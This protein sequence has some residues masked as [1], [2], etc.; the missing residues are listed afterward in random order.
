MKKLVFIL[1]A[2]FIS[3]GLFAQI[4]KDTHMLVD[5]SV[6][7]PVFTGIMK[8]EIIK[9]KQKSHETCSQFLTD[10]ISFPKEAEDRSEEGTVVVRFTVLPSGELTHYNVINSISDRLDEEVIAT[11][12]KTSGMWEPGYNNETPVAMESEV[13]VTF[14]LGFTD[15]KTMAQQYLK[16]ASKKLYKNKHKKALKYLN[17]AMVYAPNSVQ[18][19]LHRGI[20]HHKLGD[21]ASACADW[22]R[23]KEIGYEDAD[24]YITQYCGSDIFAEN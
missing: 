6:S 7:P 22:T 13:A 4:D 11:L 17:K 12:E 1:I 16:M 10:N 21:F 19:L 18:T 9:K 20:I 8:Q 14:S 15:H 5:V 24:L 23:L 3:P 2:L